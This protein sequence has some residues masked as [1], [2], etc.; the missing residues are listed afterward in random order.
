MDSN[1]KRGRRSSWERKRGVGKAPRACEIHCYP[2][3]MLEGKQKFMD[4]GKLPT[5]ESHGTQ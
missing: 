4:L 1:R 5:K 3:E 2:L